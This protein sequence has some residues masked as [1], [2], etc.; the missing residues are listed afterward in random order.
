MPCSS[1]KAGRVSVD[2]GITLGGDKDPVA[3]FTPSKQLKEI[4]DSP[5]KQLQHDDGS[6]RGKLLDSLC[7]GVYFV[8]PDRKITYWNQGPSA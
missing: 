8:G 2:F 6:L 5:G 1:S 3:R 7:D 4:P